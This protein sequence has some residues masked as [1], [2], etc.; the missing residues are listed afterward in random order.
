M[1]LYSDE[2]GFAGGYIAIIAILV[3]GA[4]VSIEV[5]SFFDELIT[6]NDG[7]AS[8]SLITER[9]HDYYESNTKIVNF[10]PFI[11]LFG[12]LAWGYVYALEHRGA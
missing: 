1:K 9:V 12:L 7:L 2:K 11:I 6:V 3:L 10:L 8:Q 4:I 5:G